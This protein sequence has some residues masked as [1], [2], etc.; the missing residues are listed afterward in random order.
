MSSRPRYLEDD[1]AVDAETFVNRASGLMHACGHDWSLQ[2][3]YRVTLARVLD[4]RRKFLD[5]ALR[6]YELSQTAQEAVLA[7]D[8]LELLGKA[9]TCS[10][11][12]NAG[13][14]RS[15]IL[16][17][18]C[19]DERVATLETLKQ[20]STHAQVLAKMYKE[21][22]LR[23]NEL[24]AFE[25]SLMPHQKAVAG[26]GLTIL[27]RAV[28]EH[29]MVAA[30][31]IYD[32]I[33]FEQLGVLLEIGAEKAERVAARMV[34]EARLAGAINQVDGFLHFERETDV[35]RDWDGR[36]TSVSL[37]VNECLEA[38]AQ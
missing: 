14:Q 8:L 33:A 16:G 3:R 11:L 35:L 31:K 34:S 7:D 20:Y 23:R 27:E 13:P 15:R 21:Q 36:I 1:E 28:I 9:V 10:I 38:I 12:G 2:L 17:T 18:L 6:Y 24:A 32:N 5:A 19:K 22:I 30:S 26:D 25:A 4:S 29:N 37:A